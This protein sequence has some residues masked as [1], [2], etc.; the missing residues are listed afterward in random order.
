MCVYQDS[1]IIF[2]FDVFFGLMVLVVMDDLVCVWDL[3]VGCCIGFLDG[4]IV[5]VCV[6]QV[7]DNFLVIGFMDVII[8]F[9]DF[10]KVYYDL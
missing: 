8:W 1:I 9:W 3:N 4:Y 7:E 10:S 2:D 6:F 5:L